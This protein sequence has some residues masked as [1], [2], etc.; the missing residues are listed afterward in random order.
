MAE[1][2]VG[3]EQLQAVALVGY[4]MGG[5]MVLKCAAEWGENPPAWLRAVVGV[6][7]AIDLAPSADELHT[8]RN[9]VYE[10][11]F[12]QNMLRRYRVKAKLFPDHFSLENCRRVRSIRTFDEYI[13]SPNC[14]FLGADDYYYRVAAARIIDSITVPTLILNAID[15]PFIRLTSETRSKICSNSAI[16]FMETAHGGHCAFLAQPTDTYD[17]YWAEQTLIGFISA[18]ISGKSVVDGKAGF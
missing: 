18:Q 3:R 1:Y 12:L 2:F 9:R 16:T 8:P 4:S 5:N 7:P 14:G 10:W 13:V 6:S 11:N 15:D 17:G